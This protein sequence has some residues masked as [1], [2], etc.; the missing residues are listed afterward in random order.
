MYFYCVGVRYNASRI[1]R[2][3]TTVDAMQV[4]RA[5]GLFVTRIWRTRHIFGNFIFKQKLLKT[6]RAL[7]GFESLRNS[8]KWIMQFKYV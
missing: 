5:V 7:M 6:C 8:E 1:M 2:F 4:S 3:E